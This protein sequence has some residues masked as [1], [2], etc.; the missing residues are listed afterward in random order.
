MATS[1]QFLIRKSFSTR[2]SIM[3]KHLKIAVI[4]QSVFARDVYDLIRNH[5]HTVVGVF[6]I[7]DKNGREVRNF[8]DS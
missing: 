6:T 7:P 1:V 3:T 4:G 5:G 2:P 8:K